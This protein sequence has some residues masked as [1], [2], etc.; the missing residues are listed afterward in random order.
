M[1]DETGR[2]ICRFCSRAGDLISGAHRGCKSLAR[3]R[4]RKTLDGH[5][6]PRRPPKPEH[7]QKLVGVSAADRTALPDR[8][9]VA[10]E[11]APVKRIVPSIFPPSLR[12]LFGDAN[13]KTWD[14]NGGTEI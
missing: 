2:T 10:L 9:P 13:G 3:K 11:S 8:A 12:N 1:T 4:K 5:S 7:R 6:Q 14:A